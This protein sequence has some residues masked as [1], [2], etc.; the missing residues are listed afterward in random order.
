MKYLDRKSHYKKLLE[1]VTVSEQWIPRIKIVLDS[2]GKGVVWYKIISHE[3]RVPWE[4]LAIIH[5]LECGND[6]TKHIHNGDSLAGRTVRVPKGRPMKPPKPPVK[7]EG[8]L[9]YPYTFLESCMDWAD[10][11]SANISLA[12]LHEW[13]NEVILYFLE[14][15]NGFGYV[16][17]GIETPYLWSGTNHYEEGKYIHDGVF[18]SGTV[19]QQV[20]AVPLLLYLKGLNE[21]T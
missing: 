6:F 5:Y 1:T 10:L 16:K 12:Q 3:M 15:N 20:G 19:S 7:L 17:K 13:C 4:V 11:K 18:D 21:Y 8:S 14:A 2:I 9:K